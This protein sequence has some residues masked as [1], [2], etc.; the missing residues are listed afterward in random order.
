MKYITEDT[1]EVDESLFTTL[2]DLDI[3]DDGDEWVP[4]KDEDDD[5]D[6][7]DEDCEEEE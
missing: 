5:D 7:D 4:G 6:D 3:E 1:V 2:D